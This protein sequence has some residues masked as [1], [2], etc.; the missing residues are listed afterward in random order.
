MWETRVPISNTTVKTQ[1]A[2]GTWL[3]T[4]W[5]NKWL[6]G[7]FLH[8]RVAT[9]LTSCPGVEVQSIEVGK[10]KSR[11]FNEVLGESGENTGS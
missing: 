5:E 9:A 2:D 3:V 1:A 11:R 6:P 8:A 7:N 4:A 10:P